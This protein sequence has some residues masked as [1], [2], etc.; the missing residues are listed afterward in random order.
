MRYLDATSL[1]INQSSRALTFEKRAT[2]RRSCGVIFTT[3]IQIIWMC[4]RPHGAGGCTASSWGGMN[5]P[6]SWLVKF[7]RTSEHESV[8]TMIHSCRAPCFDPW[9]ANDRQ[10]LTRIR[11]SFWWMW[12]PST[13]FFMHDL[14]LTSRLVDP[15]IQRRQPQVSSHSFGASREASWSHSRRYSMVTPC[16]LSRS[17]YCTLQTDFLVER[18]G[19]PKHYTS[20]KGKHH[21]LIARHAPY[22]LN[23]D[24]A[25]RWLEVRKLCGNLWFPNRI[26]RNPACHVALNSLMCLF[27]VKMSRVPGMSQR[28]HMEASLDSSTGVDDESKQLLM[29][30]FSHTAF[31]L[32]AGKEMTNPSNLVDYHNKMAESSGK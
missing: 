15:E 3:I 14:T 28:K 27:P 2:A 25:R 29:S 21:R 31:F 5:F 13:I 16:A 7:T 18:L 20:R 1:R 12:S 26:L 9:C 6:D 4:T 23:P 30:F 24:S 19:G 17:P 32:V 10:A 11:R 8:P 22:D